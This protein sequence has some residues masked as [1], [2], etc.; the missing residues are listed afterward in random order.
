MK[1]ELKSVHKNQ[2]CELVKK[3]INQNVMGCRWAFKNKYGMRF[4]VRLVSKG[5]TQQ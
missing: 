2:T 4:K 5:F 1:E 3:P